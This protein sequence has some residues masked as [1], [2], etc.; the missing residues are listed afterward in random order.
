MRE[1][2]RDRAAPVTPHYV[3]ARQLALSVSYALLI[4]FAS[5]RP[6]SPIGSA[7]RRWMNE[8]APWVQALLFFERAPSSETTEEISATVLAYRHVLVGS[9][10]F[11]LYSIVASRRYWPAW[12]CA[13]S[14]K[15]ERAGRS[16]A[17][18]ERLSEVVSRPLRFCIVAPERKCITLQQTDARA[19]G[20]WATA[21][22]S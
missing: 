1:S 12:T 9:I 6:E 5:Q 11:A 14:V 16:K 22:Y 3:V 20:V 18:F 13:L 2:G 21:D 7:L 19:R 15:M 8:N 17:E 10:C 4:V